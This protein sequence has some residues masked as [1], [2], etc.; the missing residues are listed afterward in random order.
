MKDRFPR[1]VAFVK[2]KNA[3]RIKNL[4]KSMLLQEVRRRFDEYNVYVSVYSYP[5]IENMTFDTFYLDI[6]AIKKKVLMD[7]SSYVVSKYGGVPRVYFTGRGF[8]MYLDLE[9]YIK[10]KHKETLR[11]WIEKIVVDSGQ[12]VSDFD[13]AVW[14]D[15]KRVSRLP[16]TL[17]LKS[18]IKRLCIPVDINWDLNDILEQS[19]RFSGSKWVEINPI[20]EMHLV[21]KEIEECE[22]EV[23]ENLKRMREIKPKIDYDNIDYELK[24]LAEYAPMLKDG[25]KR[26]LHFM[27]IPR[28]VYRGYSD[29]EILSYCRK[30]VEMS[31]RDWMEYCDYCLKSIKR[32]REGPGSGEPWKPFSFEKFI[33]RHSD[34]VLE[35]PEPKGLNTP[36]AN[37]K[38]DE[39]RGTEVVRG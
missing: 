6:D 33:L 32:T 18:G 19:M 25:C 7:F 1:D 5:E 21:E 26:M 39:R 29:L 2:D 38:V 14:G 10:I 17:N 3:W 28:L 11:A 23:E 9:R 27:V 20:T 30:F 13:T 37:K 22:K 4:D 34:I 16:F 12:K 24:K 35:P 36:N 15:I 8:A 31:G